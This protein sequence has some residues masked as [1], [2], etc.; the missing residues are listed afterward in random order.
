MSQQHPDPQTGYPV[1]PRPLALSW[2]D[3]IPLAD[4]LVHPRLPG[5]DYPFDGLSGAGVAFKLAWAIAKRICGGEK[6]TPKLRDFLLDAVALAALGLV[7]RRADVHT[8]SR[9]TKALNPAEVGRQVEPI[10]SGCRLS[11][12][13]SPQN[14]GFD[15]PVR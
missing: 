14:R 5:T 8:G 2:S 12:G 6:V 1:S 13:T 9:A 7:A 3:P 15:G 11:R 4:V 10:P